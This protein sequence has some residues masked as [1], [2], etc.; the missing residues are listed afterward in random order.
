MAAAKAPQAQLIT[1][2]GSVSEELDGFVKAT[3]LASW[4]LDYQAR[5]LRVPLR[6]RRFCARD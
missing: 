3:G 5:A 6:A 4:G 1:G 2:D